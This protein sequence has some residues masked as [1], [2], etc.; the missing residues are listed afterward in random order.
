M[1]WLPAGTWKLAPE[2]YRQCQTDSVVALRTTS[3][4]LMRDGDSRAHWGRQVVDVVVSDSIARHWLHK[5]APGTGSLLELK[6]G[7]QMQGKKQFGID[8]EWHIVGDWACLNPFLCVAY[9]QP[10]YEFA[11][12]LRDAK[13]YRVLL[14]TPFERY[15]RSRMKPAVGRSTRDVILALGGHLHWMA[16]QAG[17][18]QYISSRP[19]PPLSEQDLKTWAIRELARLR[20]PWTGSTDQSIDLPLWQEQFAT[21]SPQGVGA[22]GSPALAQITMPDSVS[23]QMRCGLHL[24]RWFPGSPL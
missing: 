22:N 12:W 14:G 7:A 6:A 11:R 15:L 1:A 23:T 16:F 17:H 9:P 2:R 3:E 18:A 19:A 5:A 8:F 13:G 24:G 21:H 4:N 10:L 20:P